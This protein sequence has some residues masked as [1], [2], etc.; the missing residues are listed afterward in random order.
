[1]SLEKPVSIMHLLSR[2]L[3][4]IRTTPPR[5]IASPPTRLYHSRLT[6]HLLDAHF[7]L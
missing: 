1:M 7:A 6:I 5:V 4:R 3:Q 2:A